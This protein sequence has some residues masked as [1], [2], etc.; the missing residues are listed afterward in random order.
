MISRIMDLH[1]THAISSYARRGV[2]LLAL[3]GLAGLAVSACSSKSSL[4]KPHHTNAPASSTTSTT[5]A[6]AAATCPLTGLPVPGGGPVP[7]RPALAVKID[8]YPDARPQSGMDKA[9][10]V[11]EEPV[12]GGI[13]RYA[14][15]FQ[16]QDAPLVG[17]VRSARNIDIGILGQLG[18]PLLVHVGGIDPVLANINASP[19]VNIDLG[20]YGSLATH[21]SGRVAP[22]DTYSTTAQLWGTRPTMTTPP[23]PLFSYSTKVPQGTTV[24][25][26]GIDFSGTSD[27]TWKYNP[28]T[29]TF[30]RYYNG[31]EA[32]MLS[33]GVQN[34]AANVIVQYV[35]ISYGPW[36][37]NSEG[38]LEVQADLYPDAS[39]NAIIFRNGTEI[40]GTWSRA[41]LGSP[42][43]FTTSSGTKIPLQPGQT[44]VELVP[45][46][47]TATTTP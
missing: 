38:G 42:T 3:A 41:A 36:L 44:W 26:V 14:A 47:I 40:T 7:Q 17:P 29:S 45:N 5:A 30:L 32:D 33:D 12:E 19:L 24:A 15:V 1:P 23:Q 39:G 43:Q 25:S 9:D 37:E 8:N 31:T 10:V 18:T 27:V 22:Y 16:C 20:S 28:T 35:Q 11:F 6:P 46:T 34:S 4:P 2:G 13:T 21:P